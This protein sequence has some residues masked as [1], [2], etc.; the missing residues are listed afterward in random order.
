MQ[1]F[2]QWSWRI[3]L[4][5]GLFCPCWTSASLT[6]KPW[7]HIQFLWISS[8]PSPSSLFLLASHLESASNIF[9]PVLPWMLLSYFSVN[10]LIK[11]CHANNSFLC[12]V[13][14]KL[15]GS[16]NELL[17]KTDHEFNLNALPWMQGTHTWA[18]DRNVYEHT[19]NIQDNRRITL[20]KRQN[21]RGK[22]RG[23]GR[24]ISASQEYLVGHTLTW[25]SSLQLV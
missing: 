12:Q 7:S 25:G 19:C 14:P 9:S 22:G 2:V 21:K 11:G 1:R 17:D 10:A 15:P 6:T 13:L 4:N 8:L 5:T 3:D 16:P 23:K 24:V 20:D 18:V